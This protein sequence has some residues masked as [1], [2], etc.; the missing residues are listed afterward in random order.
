[1]ICLSCLFQHGRNTTECKFCGDCSHLCKEKCRGLLRAKAIDKPK[2]DF[3]LPVERDRAPL[4][5]KYAIEVCPECRNP[6]PK[7][8]GQKVY[9]S[10]A[11]NRKASKD[12]GSARPSQPL[13]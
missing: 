13:T 7:T 11:C 8:S 9:C 3:V 10:V 5:K 1:M 4:I 2:H 12:S 6:F